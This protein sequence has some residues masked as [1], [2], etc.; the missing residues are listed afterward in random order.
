[1]GGPGCHPQPKPDVSP[2]AAALQLWVNASSTSSGDGSAQRPFKTLAEALARSGEGSIRIHLAAGLYAGPFRTVG[3]VQIVGGPSSVLFA[4]GSAAVLVPGAEIDFEGIAIQ[5]GSIGIDATRRVG[6]HGVRF[7]GQRSTAVLL[8]G[9]PLVADASTFSASVSETRGVVLEEDATAE[10]SGCAFLGPYRRA[11]ESKSRGS[12]RIRNSRFEGPVIGVHQT[13]GAVRVERTSFAGGRGPAIFAAHGRLELFD[14]DVHGHEYG[15]QC[16]EGAA[17]SANRLSST[18][19]DRAGIALAKASAELEEVLIADSGSF[20]GVQLVNS[21]ASLRRFWIQGGES[22]GIH[23]RDS[24][25]T[26]ADGAIT[27]IK[28]RGGHA[29]D[30][31][32]VRG[33]TATFDSIS[34]RT[35]AGAGALAAEGAQLSMRDVALESCHLAGLVAETLAKV[36]GSSLLVR[37]AGGAAIVVPGEADVQVDL[38]SS[39]HNSGGAVWAECG[40]GARVVLSRLSGDSLGGASI[41]CVRLAASPAR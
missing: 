16:G 35:V 31:V 38:L 17:L 40:S 12:V 3:P 37:S 34:I 21:A 19:A 13:A 18:R 36:R 9:A 7:T 33:G 10:I 28:D 29:G 8:R 2:P 4:E 1:M 27:Q 41:R 25:L 14:V 23:A 22:Y 20:G 30:G 6:L 5:G 11:V 39:E 24:R 32:H 15:V 26:A